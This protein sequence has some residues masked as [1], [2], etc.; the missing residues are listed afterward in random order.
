MGLYFGKMGSIKLTFLGTGTSLGVP[1][2]G[3]PCE[4][5]SSKDPRD[6]RLR[7]SV[8]ME[9]N[10]NKNS[11]E[12]SST[13]LKTTRLCI[14]AGPDFREQVLR[15]NIQRIDAILLTHEHRD[16]VAGLDDVR[17]F[18]Y[19]QQ[20]AMPVYG[21]DLA[22]EGLKKMFYYSFGERAYPGIPEFKLIE[23]D[24]SQTF[25]INGIEIMP[26]E[27]MHNKLRTLAY[28]IGKLAYIT[29]AK[30]IAPEEEKKLYG[31]EILVVNA[32]RKE[33]HFS[34]FCLD[35]AL[36]LIE[37]VKP[38]EAYL[39]HLSHH[40]GPYKDYQ[41]ELPDNVHLAYDGLSITLEY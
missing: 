27:V 21:N 41:K 24:K 13:S 33:S 14:D 22:L 36:A 5:C 7:S 39:T 11:D 25:S 26:I 10:S 6:K 34:H 9:I 32:L 4:V 30:T 1:I 2:I 12:D 31:V 19:L 18:N 8:F 28:R 35:E 17:A 23:V 29:D 37:R 3:C 15:E 16:H 38:K 40:M 20:C